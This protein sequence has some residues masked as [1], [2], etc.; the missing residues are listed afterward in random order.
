M[1]YLIYPSYRD[2]FFL[3]KDELDKRMVDILEED[4]LLRWI[5]FGEIPRDRHYC[6]LFI[7]QGNCKIE[8]FQYIR[9]AQKEFDKEK[10]FANHISQNGDKAWWGD[11]R[12]NNYIE[13]GKA[14][15]KDG[16]WRM[17]EPTELEGS[18]CFNVD[19]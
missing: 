13:V 15:I 16:S 11:D 14:K 12:W 2:I 9:D 10:I 8:F 7:H 17:E 3:E 4:P 18:S 1:H 5:Y 19:H 6:F